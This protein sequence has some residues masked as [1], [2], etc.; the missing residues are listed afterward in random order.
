LQVHDVSTPETTEWFRRLKQTLVTNGAL[1]LQFLGQTKMRLAI[2][3]E[4]D[5]GVAAHAV[6]KINAQSQ[7]ETT[8]VAVRTVKNG[9]GTV[10]VQVTDATK[11]FGKGRF[12]SRL[13]VGI[14]AA[15]FGR[16]QGVA[17]HAHDLRDGVPVQRFVGILVGQFA[18]LF[19]AEPARV[20]TARHGMTQFAGA[21][22]VRTTQD[23]PGRT[24]VVCG[25]QFGGRKERWDFRGRVVIDAVAVAAAGCGRNH[26]GRR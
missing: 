15:I 26:H 19:A 3:V 13:A 23:G 2:V 21:G 6:P 11:V 9:S 7:S 25:S 10:I 1:T 4:C 18:L 17:A 12:A 14:D 8:N 5:T 22:V 24:I 16:L 20:E